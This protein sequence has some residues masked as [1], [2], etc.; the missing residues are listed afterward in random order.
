MSTVVKPF[1][2]GEKTTANMKLRK[3]ITDLHGKSTRMTN[4]FYRWHKKSGVGNKQMTNFECTL[5]DYN[6]TWDPCP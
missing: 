3:K 6:K 5:R 2:A 4:S 1:E